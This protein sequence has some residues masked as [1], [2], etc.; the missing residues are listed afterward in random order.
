MHAEKRSKMRGEADDR[1]QR[2]RPRVVIF[3]AAGAARVEVLELPESACPGDRICH[4][5]RSWLITSS[6]TG[7]RVLIA[8]L[9]AN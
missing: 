9:E 3:D 7:T 1:P 5:G 8:E 4:R 2:S 6:R